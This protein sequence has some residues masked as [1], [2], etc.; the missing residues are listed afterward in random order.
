MT[1]MGNYFSMPSGSPRQQLANL[2][3]DINELPLGNQDGSQSRAIE[4]NKRYHSGMAGKCKRPTIKCR[5]EYKSFRDIAT[6]LNL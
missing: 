6:E 5:F 4:V 1:G 2:T 3:L